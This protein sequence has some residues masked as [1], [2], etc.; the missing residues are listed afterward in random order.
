VQAH[1]AIRD[2]SKSWMVKEA[3]QAAHKARQAV[4][5][6]RARGDSFAEGQGL[7]ALALALVAKGS[8]KEAINE[9]EEAIS[10]F[11]RLE[12]TASES[13]MLQL[14]S[15]LHMK[16][17]QPDHALRAAKQLG[18]LSSSLHE[19]AMALETI[20][21]VQLLQNDRGSA[22]RTVEDLLVLCDEHGDKKRE[23]VAK[24]MMSNVL[25]A[26][27]DTSE[28][29]AIAREAQAILN[30]VGA[31]KEE[32]HALRVIAEVHSLTREVDASLRAA[33]K[34]RRLLQQAGDQAE[35]ASVL[36]LIVQI[37]LGALMTMGAATLGDDGAEGI[38]EYASESIALG[39][40]AVALAA[41]VGNE[42]L[43]GS[44]LCVVAQMQM[45]VSQIAAAERSTS[46]AMTIFQHAD[47]AR[48]Q[49]CVMCIQ[50]DLLLVRGKSQAALALADKAR[51]IFEEVDDPQGIYVAKG[52]RE[53]IAGPEVKPVVAEQPQWSQE[54]WEQW[55]QWQLQ[56]SQQQQQPQAQQQAMPQALAERKRP[57]KEVDIG[58]KLNMTA[59]THDAVQQKLSAL[60]NSSLDLDE[61]DNF[62]MDSPLM[63]LGVTSRLAVE[64]RNS[65]AEEFPGINLPFTLIFDYPSVVHMTE[66]ILEET[67]ATAIA[68]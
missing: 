41:G 64:L 68:G 65:M 11:Q 48:N 47:D 50:A 15:G 30:D 39:E 6:F 29:V 18:G 14:L 55:Q 23:G 44:A 49:G 9:G 24:L 32:A 67:G 28:A 57:K 19:R 3:T 5:R 10:I 63:A 62:E 7:S 52:I 34:A 40:E 36:F 53:H 21:E 51:D 2:I 43:A 4:A 54:E 17:G 25:V 31:V 46:E 37:R 8:L 56:Q 38:H 20:Y 42:R 22:R 1:L 35:E 58:A 16:V 12:D 27:G 26:E 13:S 61:D 59:L 45:A 33:G 66:M 60:V